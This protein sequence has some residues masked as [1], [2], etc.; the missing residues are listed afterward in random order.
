[1]KTTG[2][3]LANPEVK[4]YYRVMVSKISISVKFCC[5]LYLEYCRNGEIVKSG[6]IKID[7][8]ERNY[9]LEEEVKW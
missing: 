6:E 9:S 1:M 2:K 7:P 4:D 3:G 8:K 5:R